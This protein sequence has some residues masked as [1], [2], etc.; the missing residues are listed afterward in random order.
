[1]IYST[2]GKPLLLQ[3]AIKVIKDDKIRKNRIIIKNDITKEVIHDVTNKVVVAGSAFTAQKHFNINAPVKTPTYNNVL[4]LENTVNETNADPGLRRDEMV[5]LFAIGNDGCGPEQHQVFDVKYGSWIKVENLIPLRYCPK[6]SDLSDIDRGKYFGRKVTDDRYIY[7][8]KAFE[9]QPQFEQRYIDGTPID[10]N[11]YSSTK[12]EDIESFVQIKL[13]I[14]SDDCR[15][16]FKAINDT[17]GSKISSISLLTAWKKNVGGKIYY[18]DIRPLTKLHFPNESLLED[19]KALDIT[20][21][22]FY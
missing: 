12:T 9:T 8:F 10:E 15:E 14:T 17:K 6:N 7:Y 5:C 2:E 22:I 13:K 4:N 11:I 18:Q 21:L 20:Y 3:E 16:Y 1:M 19:S